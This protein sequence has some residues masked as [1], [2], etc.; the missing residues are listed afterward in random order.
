MRKSHAHAVIALAAALTTT[1]SPVPAKALDLTGYGTLAVGTFWTQ[2]EYFNTTGP[3][4]PS[5]ASRTD[6]DFSN[7]LFGDSRVGVRVKDGDYSGIAEIGA[8]NPKAYSKGPQVRLLFGKYDFGNGQIMVGRAG[9]PYV[10]RTQQVYDADGGMNGYGSLYDGFSAQIKLTMNNGFYVDLMKPSVGNSTNNTT[11]VSP[12][13]DVLAAYSQTGNSYQATYTD[14]KN[15][16]PKIVIGY[17]G[18]QDSWTYGGGVAYNL[19]DVKSV[20]N[21]GS[22]VTSNV[23]SYLF[24]FHGKNEIAPVEISYNIFTGRNVGD[25]L[26]MAT[27]NGISNTLANPGSA[28]GAY[29]DSLHGI[30]SYSYGGWLQL[31]Y[32]VNEKTKVYAAASYVNDDNKIA[33]PDARMAAFAQV[34]YQISKHFKV[35][36]EVGYMDDMKNGLGQKEPKTMYAGSKWEM[37]F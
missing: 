33:K 19:Y 36:P 24:F 10:Y 22:P 2:T 27:G 35:V 25:L 26:S 8:Y 4:G 16:L 9:S 3:T 34:Q 37:S 20:V 11:N 23:H 1:L 6:S 31:G 28:N 13:A 29:F 7:D 21:N 15:Y 30:D 17:E 32:T 18:K 14:Y 5:T 12:S